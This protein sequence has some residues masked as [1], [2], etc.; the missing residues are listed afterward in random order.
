LYFAGA[1]YTDGED[2]VSVHT[3]AQSAQRVIEE[4]N[5]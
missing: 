2:W 1:E 4:I 3:A 5:N